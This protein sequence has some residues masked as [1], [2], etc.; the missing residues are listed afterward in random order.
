MEPMVKRRNIFLTWLIWP[1]I[2]LGIY[3]LVWWYKIN[4]EAR[5]AGIEVSP[6][7]ALLA[8]LI[9]W[10]I[11]VP[12]F[13][14]VFRTGSRIAEMQRRAGMAASC[15][16]LIGLILSFFAGLHA[17]YYQHELNRIWHHQ[18]GA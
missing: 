6:G 8:I 5:D 4:S 15:S 11:I 16:G 1:F 9:G 3:H 13:V 18:T 14:S 17:L 10:I 2:T 12:P 7:V